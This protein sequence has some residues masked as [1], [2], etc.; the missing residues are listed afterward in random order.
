[1]S[2]KVCL[3]TGATSGIGAATAS[4]LAQEGARVVLLGRNPE[5]TQAVAKSIQQSSGNGA[6]D[7]LLADL[8]S[9]QE[10]RRA[11]EVF[12]GRYERLDVLVNNAGGIFLRRQETVDGLEMTF[13]VNHLAYFL[14][15][16]L[17]V[18]MLRASAP[19]RVINIS[20]SSHRRAKLDLSDLQ[21]KRGY[22]GFRAYARSKRANLLF[23]LELARRLEGSGVTANALDPGIV[24]TNIGTNNGRP[25]WLANRLFMLLFRKARVGPELPAQTIVYLATSPRVAAISGQL[26]VG[27]QL[28]P[29]SA[30]SRDP[31]AGLKLWEESVRL[32][33]LRSEE[34]LGLGK[35]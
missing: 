35:E 4:A 24:L 19:A 5:K 30:V 27:Q 1:M 7:W 18:D 10:I 28:V 21:L 33:G 17:L 20:S 22:R 8:S 26:F 3:V 23:T 34:S 2:E 14:L 16:C 9:Q 11:V 13:A 29:S 32:T 12:K 31:G 25:G 6:V 15:T